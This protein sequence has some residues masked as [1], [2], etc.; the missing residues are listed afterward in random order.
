MHWRELLSL[1]RIRQIRSRLPELV[2]QTPVVPGPA[3]P[4]GLFLKCE[5]LQW[6]GAYKVRAAFALLDE[7]PPGKAI[8]LSSSGNFAGAL[9]AA[10]RHRKVETHLVMMESTAAYKVEKVRAAGGRVVFCENLYLARFEKLEELAAQGL[11]AV[12]HRQHPTVIAAHATVGLELVEQLPEMGS[13]VVPVS[14]GG[15]LAGVALAVKSL[16]P[17]VKVY[18]VQPE[19]S[20]AMVASLAAGRPVTVEVKTICDA[21]TASRPAELPLQ[22]ISELVEEVVTVSETTVVEAVKKLALESKMVVEPGAATSLAAVLEGKVPG[23]E[24]VCLLLSGGNVGAD[25]LIRL[26]T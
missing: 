2:R 12:D 13:V 23:P 9:A 6:T 10:G 25:H 8:A 17:E 5:N 11:V 15:L 4:A 20:Q 14:T 7:L 21:L 19:G 22:M 24:P 16:R 3:D 18:G 26:L 1:E